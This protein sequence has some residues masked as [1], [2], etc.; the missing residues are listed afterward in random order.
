MKLSI[1]KNNLHCPII[2]QYPEFTG[3]CGRVNTIIGDV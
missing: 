1:I 2:F 3:Y